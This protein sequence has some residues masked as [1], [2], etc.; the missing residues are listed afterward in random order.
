MQL[1]PT[2]VVDDGPRE[3]KDPGGKGLGSVVLDLII[4]P[5]VA[6]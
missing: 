3:E 5:N 4:S 2:V 6:S 1:R